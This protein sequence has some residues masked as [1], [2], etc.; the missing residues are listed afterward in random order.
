MTNEDA[1][2]QAEIAGQYLEE[3]GVRYFATQFKP[4]ADAEAR[5]L[6]LVGWAVAVLTFG[7]KVQ[8]VISTINLAKQVGLT[9]EEITKELEEGYMTNE[10]S[11]SIR[12]RIN[13]L[14]MLE[15]LGEGK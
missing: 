5:S 11:A 4:E 7:T 1:M 3:A 2:K 9:E 12:A 10:K 6:V 14:R 8:N 13:E 15:K